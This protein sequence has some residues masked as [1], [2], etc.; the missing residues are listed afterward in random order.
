[1]PFNLP[2]AD[3]PT[4]DGNSTGLDVERGSVSG[5]DSILNCIDSNSLRTLQRI[6]FDKA[7]TKVTPACH[8]VSV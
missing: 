2:G 5:G 3:R 6:K 1:M 7:F 4:Q 8:M